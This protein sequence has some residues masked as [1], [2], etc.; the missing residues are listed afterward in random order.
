VRAERLHRGQRRVEEDADQKFAP[1]GAFVNAIW[2]PEEDAIIK[3]RQQWQRH[4]SE[5][6]LRQYFRSADA[7]DYKGALGS[8]R[9]RGNVLDDLLSRDPLEAYSGADA[10][11]RVRE[12]VER[13]FNTVRVGNLLLVRSC[14]DTKILRLLRA[15]AS[16]PSPVLVPNT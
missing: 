9:Y 1:V 16:G 12:A 13:A 11:W 8:I 4:F 10:N 3:L 6:A 2:M 15:R 7:V 14:D 5:R